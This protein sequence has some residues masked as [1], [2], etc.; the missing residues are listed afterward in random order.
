MPPEPG[1]S[2]QVVVL[3][4]DGLTAC[5]HRRCRGEAR[6]G[7]AGR[8]AASTSR[9]AHCRRRAHESAQQVAG[10]VWLLDFSFGC[11]CTH[12]SAPSTLSNYG[13]VSSMRAT[14]HL[15]ATPS[16]G[17]GP[18]APPAAAPPWPAGLP[19]PPNAGRQHQQPHVGAETSAATAILGP[20]A[21]VLPST[22]P[23][24]SPHQ[25]RGPHRPSGTQAGS[26]AG[27]VR[28]HCC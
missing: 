6:C 17:Q 7:Q 1:R 13:P 27:P 23:L 15:L 4:G 26:C 8:I 28:P 22:A 25:R 5:T 10:S 12:G 18:A 9:R 24:P 11:G 3:Q 2:R 19:P 14:R 21:D 20:A 16:P